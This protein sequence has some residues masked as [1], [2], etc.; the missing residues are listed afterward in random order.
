MGASSTLSEDSSL[1]SEFSLALSA[2]T[3]VAPGPNFWEGAMAT[4]FPKGP[5][6]GPEAGLIW[7]IFPEGFAWVADTAGVA[8]PSLSDSSSL[9]LS[10]SSSGLTT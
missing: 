9:L 2:F 4:S 7:R 10:E 6:V 8:S 1:L 3:W 5:L